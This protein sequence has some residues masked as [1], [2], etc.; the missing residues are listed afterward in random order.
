M[1]SVLR[2]PGV[3]RVLSTFTA[4]TFT[5]ATLTAA[6]LTAA[7]LGTV[8]PFCTFS[9]DSEAGDKMIVYRAGYAAA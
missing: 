1:L 5:A 4:A 2:V 6:T 9:T 8:G 7:T 3:L